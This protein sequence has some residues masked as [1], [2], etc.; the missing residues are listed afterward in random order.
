MT[1]VK[2]GDR[3]FSYAWGSR[4]ES[5]HQEYVTVHENLMGLMLRDMSLKSVVA[6]PNK[7]VGRMVRSRFQQKDGSDES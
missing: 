2:V 5:A 7:F 6:V 4:Q 3:V 1:K